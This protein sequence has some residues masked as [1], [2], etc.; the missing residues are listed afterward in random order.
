MAKSTDQ[1]PSF[2]TGI[3]ALT[4]AYAYALKRF[5]QRRAEHP[6][7]DDLV[8]EVFLRLTRRGALDD[9]RNLEGYVF[10]TAANVL[11]ARLRQRISHREND[12]QAIDENYAE[13][14]AFSPERVLLGREAIEHLSL[15]V[16]KLPART[17]AVFLL[18][19]VEGLPHADVARRLG[20][21]ISTVDKHMAKAMNHLMKWMKE[22]F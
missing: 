14:T 15:A 8:Q 1:L 20:V 19:R 11:R 17:R 3:E 12:H 5:F 4:R 2:G 9:I 22:H 16:Q 10:Q 13:A 6:D 18:C 7:V 21:G